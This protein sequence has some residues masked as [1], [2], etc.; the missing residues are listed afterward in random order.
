CGI[1]RENNRPLVSVGYHVQAI[2]SGRQRLTLNRNVIRER[3]DR[4][5]VR[6]RTPNFVVRNFLTP[7]RPACHQRP[8][9]VH[10]YV[11]QPDALRNDGALAERWQLQLRSLRS[12]LELRVSASCQAPAPYHQT[13]KTS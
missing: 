4:V 13:E 10:G 8:A 5:F 9:I 12:I 3:N 2:R 6:T 1:L 7:Q 11:G